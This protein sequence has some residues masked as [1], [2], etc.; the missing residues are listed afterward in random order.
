[1]GRRSTRPQDRGRAASSSAPGREGSPLRTHSLGLV[2]GWQRWMTAFRVLRGT[3][4]P[5]GDTLL[6][7]PLHKPNRLWVSGRLMRDSPDTRRILA[8]DNFETPR[9]ASRLRRASQYKPGLRLTGGRPL[10]CSW[11]ALESGQMTVGTQRR[12][13]CCP[14]CHVRAVS[15]SWMQPWNQRTRFKEF[16]HWA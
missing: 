8:G 11:A 14:P 4:V 1:M 15:A 6:E 12:A 9:S 2:H 13:E 7:A 3:S 5:Y 16:W 10:S